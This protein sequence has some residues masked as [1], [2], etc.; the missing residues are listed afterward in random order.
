MAEILLHPAAET[1]PM[2]A[3]AVRAMYAGEMQEVTVWAYDE[4]DAM[5]IIKAMYEN[6]EA[7]RK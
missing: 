1:E 7:A 3:Y 5:D 4:D 2:H 6:G